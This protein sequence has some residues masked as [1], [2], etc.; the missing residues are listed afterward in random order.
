[1]EGLKMTGQG[2]EPLN[3][4][5]LGISEEKQSH[6]ASVSRMGIEKVYLRRWYLSSGSNERKKGAM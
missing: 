1:L 3:L 2:W 4:Q 6:V 5:E